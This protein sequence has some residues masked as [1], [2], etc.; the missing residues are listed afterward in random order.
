MQ[1]TDL[2][3]VHS[4][5]MAAAATATASLDLSG[6][7]HKIILEVPTMTLAAASPIYIQGSS[8]GSTF[9]RIAQDTNSATAQTNDLMLAS[10]LANRMVP[11]S[12]FGCRYLKIETSAAAT[13]T[14]SFKV[15]CSG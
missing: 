14:I 8:D 4:V 3:I 1:P 12:I 10:G 5:S 15:I 9:R 2:P 6:A 13:A 7:F 11:V